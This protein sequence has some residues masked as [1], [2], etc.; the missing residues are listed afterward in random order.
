MDTVAGA[1]QLIVDAASRVI[2]NVDLVSA[3]L[4]AP[5]GA[6]ST[7]ARAGDPALG[8]DAL[9]LDEVQYRS[10]LG[11]CL[12]AARPD[13]PPFAA[14]EDLTAE[15]RWPD[16]AAVAAGHGCTA[17]LSLRLHPAAG[18]DQVA[19]SLNLYSCHPHR[20]T[21]TDRYTAVLLATHGSLALAR[22]RAA[23]LAGARQDQLN[24]AID[25]R[26]VIGQAKGILMHREGISAADAFELLRRT[27]QELNIKL[28]DLART[29]ADRHG[30]LDDGG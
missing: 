20:M 15:T 4:R 9:E 16:F 28:V 17:V 27:S 21:S 5:D 12:D 7:P 25:S 26:D 29:L 8:W 30:E 11:P 18:P 2:S 23:E 22:A 19:G 10:G 6:Y 13:G 14:S 3:T 1:L 24:R